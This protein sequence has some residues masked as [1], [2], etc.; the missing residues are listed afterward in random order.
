MQ[1]TNP[2]YRQ[3]LATDVKV[4]GCYDDHDYGNNDAG[5]EL[6]AK[7]ESQ[8]EFLRFIRAS[9]G[10]SKSRESNSAGREYIR[11]NERAGVYSS[12][13]RAFILCTGVIHTCVLYSRCTAWRRGN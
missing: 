7:H 6:P 2:G 13:V 10:E 3:F 12:H 5:S 9:K 8:R 11:R 4:E 1:M